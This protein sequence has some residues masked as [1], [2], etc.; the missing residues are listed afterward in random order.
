MFS[1][2]VNQILILHNISK[3]LLLVHCF[4]LLT[5]EVYV[6]I[7]FGFFHFGILPFGLIKCR[8]YE[9]LVL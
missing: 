7:N 6:F 9:I 1:V 4:F 2:Y 5:N 8:Y 3:F